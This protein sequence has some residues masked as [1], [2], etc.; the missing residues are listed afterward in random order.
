MYSKYF[1][2]SE[3]LNSI[4]RSQINKIMFLQIKIEVKKII[5]FKVKKFLNEVLSILL[6]EG[7]IWGFKFLS[8]FKLEI[9]LKYSNLDYTNII[10][11]FK[12]YS[13]SSSKRCYISYYNL[14]ALCHNNPQ[15]LFLLE[16]NK[17]LISNK[18]ALLKGVGGNLLLKIN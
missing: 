2:L 10:T 9:I 4:M 18:E 15:S 12:I 16:T 17:G 5:S 3:F 13:K 6:K 11:S 14:V 1:F 8:K 7:F